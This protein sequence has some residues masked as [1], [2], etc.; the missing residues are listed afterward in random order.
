MLS[1]KEETP[2]PNSQRAF[3]L[4]QSGDTDAL[5]QFIEQHPD[6]SEA[7]DTTGASLLI[8]SPFRGRRDLGELIASKKATRDIFEAAALGRLDR[9]KELLREASLHTDAGA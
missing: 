6:P 5:R 9:L 8:H 2:M 7:R 1:N 4:L 3:E